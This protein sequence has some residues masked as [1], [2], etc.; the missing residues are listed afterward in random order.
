MGHTWRATVH[1]ECYVSIPAPG[2]CLLRN[3]HRKPRLNKYDHKAAFIL[4]QK[5]KRK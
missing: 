1:G 3:D 4:E 5:Q 2:K